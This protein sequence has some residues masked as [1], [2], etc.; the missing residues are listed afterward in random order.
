MYVRTVGGADA[1]SVT[2]FTAEENEEMF[3]FFDG[4]AAVANCFKISELK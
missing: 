4:S 1:V 3:F 2:A